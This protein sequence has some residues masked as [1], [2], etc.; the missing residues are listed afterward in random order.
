[1]EATFRATLP[2]GNCSDDPEWYFS[3]DSSSCGLLTLP[4]NAPA[5]GTFS[6]VINPDVTIYCT[7]K[8]GLFCGT[9][10]ITSFGDS[11]ASAGSGFF[12]FAGPARQNRT[13][14]LLYTDSGANNA[15]FEGGIL[16]VN[17][18]PLRRGPATSSR[19][20]SACDGEF[21]MDMNAFAAGTAGGNPDPFLQVV[22]TQ[23][24]IQ[25]WGRDSIA[26]GSFLSNALQF[27]V[28]P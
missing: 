6:A 27:T 5:S 11:S 4:P 16:C 15:P 9:P 3:V 21:G 26:T 13:G 22:G 1:M 7:G 24:N 28:C 8:S 14:L 18:A 20:L 12:I 17:T 10:A 19:G 23:V 25:W 2:P